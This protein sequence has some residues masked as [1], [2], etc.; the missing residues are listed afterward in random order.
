MILVLYIWVYVGPL[1]AVS[2]PCRV[3]FERQLSGISNPFQPAN[4]RSMSIIKLS[5]NPVLVLTMRP[6]CVNVWLDF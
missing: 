4:I 6:G 1:C 3:G 5:V 2:R